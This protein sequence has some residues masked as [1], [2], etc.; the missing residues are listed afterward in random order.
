MPDIATEQRV[1]VPAAEAQVPWRPTDELEPTPL[2][3]GQ[4]VRRRFMRNK[5]AVIALVVIGLL[6]IIAIPAEFTAP[7]N[8]TDRFMGAINLPPQSVHFVDEESRLSWPFAYGV[9]QSL[10]P[11][12]FKRVFVLDV[13]SKHYVQLFPQVPTYDLVGI[14]VDRKLFGFANGAGHLLGTDNQGRDM[15]SRT[16]HGGRVSLLVGLIGVALSM[17]IGT[18][19]GL[20]SGLTG[21]WVDNLIQRSIEV[22]LTFPNIPLWMAFSAAIPDTWTPVQVF[23]VMSI[24]ISFIGWTPLARVVRGITLSIKA[25]EYVTASRISGASGWWIIR[26]HLL[27][28]NVSY[29]IVS[30]TLAVPS[31]ILAETA[32]SFLGLGIR[33]PMVS[34]GSLLQTSQDIN[35]IANQP[36][37]VFSAAVP[38]VLAVLAFNFIGDGIRDAIDHTA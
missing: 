6:Y 24:I 17:I 33:P 14:T 4:L 9:K 11:K 8:T 23:F 13:E 20:I 27:P 2:T 38:V 16:I 3:H 36:W 26:H 15:L 29:I 19:V 25:E 21:G 35:V 18:L 5:L 12:T 1:L 34:W 28:G 10:D 22:I 30:L 32:L 7:Y 37:V 31:M